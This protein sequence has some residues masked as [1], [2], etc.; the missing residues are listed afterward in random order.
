MRVL[1]LFLFLSFSFVTTMVH[2]EYRVF[3]LKISKPSLVPGQPPLERIVQSSLDPEQYRGYYPVEADERVEYIDTWRC[4]G[5]T[6]NFQD[7]CQKPA[8]T[9]TGDAPTSSPQK[10]QIQDPGVSK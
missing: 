1:L 3:I 6:D 8:R 4:P 2:A 10:A 5:R 9:P 7:Y